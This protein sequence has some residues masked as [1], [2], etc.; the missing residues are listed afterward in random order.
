MEK[1]K[2]IEKINLGMG[3]NVL[4]LSLAGVMAVESLNGL[5]KLSIKMKA[6]KSIKEAAK[7]IKTI[8][9][10]SEYFNK[11]KKETEQEQK[12]EEEAQ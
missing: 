3:F 4:C 11:I 2:V 1:I 5:Y 8:D 9:E 12:G 7:V 10:L 6:D